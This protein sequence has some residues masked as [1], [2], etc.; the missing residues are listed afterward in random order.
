MAQAVAM[1]RM[2]TDTC[3]A[4]RGS[5]NTRVRPVWSVVTR[6][7]LKVVTRSLRVAGTFR[8]KIRQ[9]R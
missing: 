8:S 2:R 7:G 3:G 1:R 6:L 4:S 9:G 5:R